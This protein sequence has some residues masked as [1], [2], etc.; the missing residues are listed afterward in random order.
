V[1]VDLS[2]HKGKKIPAFFD[3]EFSSARFVK[4]AGKYAAELN[5]KRKDKV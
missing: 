4:K 2:L 3:C 5:G 1:E